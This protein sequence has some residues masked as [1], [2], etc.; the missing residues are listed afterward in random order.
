MFRQTSRPK[1][2]AHVE[3]RKR[4]LEAWNTMRGRKVGNASLRTVD[5]SLLNE[6][7]Q[8]NTILLN[9]FPSS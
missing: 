4:L 7:Y 9:T 1:F 2:S 6:A 3:R 8:S 5:S